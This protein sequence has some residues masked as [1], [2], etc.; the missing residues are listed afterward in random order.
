MSVFKI[1]NK[2]KKFDYDNVRE[3]MF[4][5][6]TYESIVEIKNKFSDIDDIIELFGTSFLF[7]SNDKYYHVRKNWFI[8]KDKN[9]NYAV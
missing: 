6:G 3:M 4:Y 2:Y 1:F 9:G 7:R 5:D 8:L